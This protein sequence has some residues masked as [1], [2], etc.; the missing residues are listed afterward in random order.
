MKL[1][2]RDG[3]LDLPENKRQAARYVADMFLNSGRVADEDIQVDWED[4]YRNISLKHTDATTAPDI[5]PLLQSS[6]EI[7][8]REP[9][10]PLM[11]I[12]GLYNRVQA[13]G[14]NTQVLAG[15]MGSV[16][17][18][19]IPE[20][21]TYPE[22]MFQIGGA[23]QT[24]YIGK[25]GIAASFTDEALLYSTWDIMALNMRLMGAALVRHKEQKAVSFLKTLGTEL[26]N[27]ASPSTSLFGVC[28]GRGLDMAANGSLRMD[29][30]FK[31][32][33]HMAEEGFQPDV[34]LINPLFFYSFIQDPVMRTMMLAHG[35]GAWFRPWNG[36][37]GPLDP[38]SNG[39]MGSQG[40]SLG[41]RIA[42]GSS[43]PGG[44][45]A[46]GIAGRE[47]GMTAA[48]PLPAPYFPWPMQVVVSPFVP[49]D[50]ESLLGDVYLLSSGNVGFHLVDEDPVTV[51][52]RDEN[53]DVVKMKIR[54]RYGFAV[55]HEGQGVGVLKNVKLARNYWDGVVRAHTMDVDAEI[56]A[57]ATIAL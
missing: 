4:M 21:G 40:P 41:N 16:T 36:Q 33:A 43:S 9:V 28:T 17:A 35:G 22:V 38:W 2:L 8:I 34:M 31:A 27:N 5:R 25:S 23:M 45:A 51:E 26:Y 53:V 54:E 7:L 44:G 42:R 57:D 55:A 47:H 3:S 13:R 49:F 14:L 52:W 1:K 19:D 15:A 30:L 39:G 46:T 48:P 50:P 20:H 37:E 24:A 32:M 56:A 18:E 12:T 29:D 11:V 6:L 10:E